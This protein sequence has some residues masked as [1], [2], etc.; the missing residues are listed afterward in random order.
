MRSL[1]ALNLEILTQTNEKLSDVQT[2]G[3][4]L[5][6]SIAK[7]FNY[8]NNKTDQKTE[9]QNFKTA[10]LMLECENDGVVAIFRFFRKFLISV[11]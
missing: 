10:E 9:K 11:F 3:K 2:C 6:I 5:M 1:S 7:D 4:Q 8:K